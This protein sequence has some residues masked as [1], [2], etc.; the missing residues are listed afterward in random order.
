MVLCTATFVVH[1]KHPDQQHNG[2]D[3]TPQEEIE[4]TFLP[5]QV[6]F[7]LKHAQILTSRIQDVEIDIMVVI[8][9]RLHAHRSINHT[10]LLTHHRHPFRH[11]HH[12]GVNNP[13]HLGGKRIFIGRV[14]IER[15]VLFRRMS[16]TAHLTMILINQVQSMLHLNGCQTVLMVPQVIIGQSHQSRCLHKIISVFLSQSKRT[17]RQFEIERHKAKLTHQF[18]DEHPSRRT[19]LISIDD[20]FCQR[21]QGR[22]LKIDVTTLLA[23][24]EQANQVVLHL[25]SSL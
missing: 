25:I 17:I 16:M 22:H 15:I 9:L 6:V 13:S 12:F 18:L 21:V 1:I 24:G 3:K 20:G 7:L 8:R 5:H 10:Q 2:Q 23:H 11:H 14:S 19:H 4:N